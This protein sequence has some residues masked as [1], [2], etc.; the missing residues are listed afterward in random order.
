[1]REIKG[2]L[3]DY[4]GKP[5]HVV[6]ITTNGVVKKSNGEC[7]MG[8]GCAREAKDKI[9]GIAKELGDKIK[10]RGNVLHSL[11]DSKVLAFPVKHRWNEM[12]DLDLI[13]NST[14]QLK[15]LATKLSGFTFVLPRPGCGN[16]GRLWREVEPIVKDLPDNVFVISK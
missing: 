3:W 2:N 13:R 12:A 5:M 16:G 14:V 10:A 7:V 15:D 8:R 9:R 11:D 6:C 1:M 4:Y